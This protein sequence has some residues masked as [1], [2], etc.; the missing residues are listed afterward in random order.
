MAASYPS[1]NISPI[2]PDQ[3]RDDQYSRPTGGKKMTLRNYVVTRE[4]GGETG[5]E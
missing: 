4:A 3:S 2:A 1:Y 5:W